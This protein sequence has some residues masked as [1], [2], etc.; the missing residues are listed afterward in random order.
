MWVD[1]NHSFVFQG[2]RRTEKIC[3]ERLPKVELYKKVYS[4]CI[5]TGFMATTLGG[6]WLQNSHM[7]IDEYDGDGDG[8]E[9][10]DLLELPSLYSGDKR[11]SS[12]KQQLKQSR[13]KKGK[14]PFVDE[15]F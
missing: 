8:D 11:S 1:F 13:K 9:E 6:R 4:K 15:T 12:S 10:G 3:R 2:I 5:A 7:L 14:L